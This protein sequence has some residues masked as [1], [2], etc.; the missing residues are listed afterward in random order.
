MGIFV[1]LLTSSN[2]VQNMGFSPWKPGSTAKTAG[3]GKSE[4]SVIL[5]SSN[6]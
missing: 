6:I 3:N 2:E 1:R 5:F 4:L